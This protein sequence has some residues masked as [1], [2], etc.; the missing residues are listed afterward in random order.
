MVTL[1]FGT[2][3]SFSAFRQRWL[4]EWYCLGPNILSILVLI[5]I[6]IRINTMLWLFFKHFKLIQFRKKIS[7]NVYCWHSTHI[8]LDRVGG[9]QSTNDKKDQY[10]SVAV[11]LLAKT[12][13][14]SFSLHKQT[15]TYT[16]THKHARTL[17]RTQELI[18][19]P[20]HARTHTHTRTQAHTRAHAR[21][22]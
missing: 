6:K 21:S 2:F 1:I 8:C 16:H 13:L 20:T 17:T 19:S 12:C 3:S 14:H 7:T 4:G 5:G 10:F 22:H 9:S 11:D 18:H 15:N